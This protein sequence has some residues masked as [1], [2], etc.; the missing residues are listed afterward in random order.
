MLGPAAIRSLK[1]LVGAVALVALGACNGRSSLLTVGPGGAPGGGSSGGA[2]GGSGIPAPT[3]PDPLDAGRI[4]IHRLNNFEYD[5]TMKDLL[6]V[7]GMAQATFQPD[8]QGEFDN[9]ADAFTVNDARYEAY[10]NNAD[11]I[12]E[13]V[14]ADT[15]PTG[16]LQTYVYGLVS[17]ACTPRRRTRPAPRRSSPP[18]ARRR[19]AVR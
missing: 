13:E 6:G 14:F 5:N 9:E 12:G 17:P 2:G 8:E 1:R 10:F 15:S 3:G 19:G 16:L 11:A 7:D 18:L 4:D